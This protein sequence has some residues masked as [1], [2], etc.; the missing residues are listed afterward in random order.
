MSARDLINA[1]LDGQADDNIEAVYKALNTRRGV[2]RQRKAAEM[3]ETLQPGDKVRL[4]ENISPKYLAGEAATVKTVF[5]GQALIELDDRWVRE[6]AAA[7]FGSA[8]RVPLDLLD[9]D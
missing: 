6:R 1:I 4:G 9:T 5:G 7:R 8:I 2:I 3:Q